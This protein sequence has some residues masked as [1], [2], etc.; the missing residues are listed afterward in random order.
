MAGAIFSAY[1][2]FLSSL[3]RYCLTFLDYMGLR[4]P[5]DSSRKEGPDGS[6]IVIEEDSGVIL[7]V[8]NCKGCVHFLN[9]PTH[10][11]LDN[12]D[13]CA[14]HER[15]EFVVRAQ[16][17]YVCSSS[18]G[19]YVLRASGTLQHPFGLGTT[20]AALVQGAVAPSCCS[21]REQLDFGTHWLCGFLMTET[22]LL[23]PYFHPNQASSCNTA[24]TYREEG[25]PLGLQRL[26]LRAAGQLFRN[27]DMS[28]G[29]V[30]FS[31]LLT[32]SS[33][34]SSCSSSDLDTQSTESFYQDRSISLG[35]LIRIS[36]ILHISQIST[37]G[38]QPESAKA[39]GK[40][41]FNGPFTWLFTLCLKPTCD[42]HTRTNNN[43]SLASFLEQERSETSIP[44]SRSQTLPTS[45][46]PNPAL[47]NDRD[48]D[49]EP[50]SD[51]RIGKSDNKRL[52]EMYEHG[53]RFLC[54]CFFKQ[55]VD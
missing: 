39:K 50:S 7:V 32:V 9:S 45:D 54:A 26:N 35:N 49:K 29:S 47:E 41:N 28:A 52:L 31:T 13:N 12:K 48:V 6:L 19:E 36:M 10:C 46:A 2:T 23:R 27:R 38:S 24:M 20:A 37:R 16:M 21:N 30:S 43:K 42:D 17:G 15:V 11:D 18:Q 8:H 14:D 25:W 5:I 40:K 53:A 4:L 1:S 33:S 34:P 3:L 51:N 22:R 55:I 44:C